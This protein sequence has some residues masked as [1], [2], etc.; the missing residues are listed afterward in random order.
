MLTAH[1]PPSLVSRFAFRDPSL[2]WARARLEAEHLVLT[3]WTWRGRYRR[4]I[5]FSRI[6][7]VDV[8]G[9]DELVLWLVDGEVLRLRL[10]RARRWKTGIE[11]RMEAPRR[12]PGA[13][14][15]ED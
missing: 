15:D 13:S 2:W 11:A 12:P 7:H 5:A 8:R 10:P 14:S 1:A 6:L 3:G 9:Q 4:S